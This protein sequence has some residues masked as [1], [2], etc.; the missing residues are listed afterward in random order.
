MRLKENGRFE[1]ARFTF[2][3]SY[4]KTQWVSVRNND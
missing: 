2:S 1:D 4:L 3:V